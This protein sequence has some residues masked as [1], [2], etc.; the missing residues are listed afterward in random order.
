MI[1]HLFDA[2]NG[3]G[4]GRG[5]GRGGGRG[6]DRT[7][8][9]AAA[10]SSTA[11]STLHNSERFLLNDGCWCDRLCSSLLGWFGRSFFNIFFI[12]FFCLQ[13]FLLLA[14]FSGIHRWQRSNIRR[15]KK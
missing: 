7:A 6:S 3:G 4:R 15:L 2:L 13:L 12:P 14:G 9:A 1:D 8:A 11:A 10:G 5:G